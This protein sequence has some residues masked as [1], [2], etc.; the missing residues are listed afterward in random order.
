MIRNGQ[1]IQPKPKI[2]RVSREIPI[3]YFQ[4]QFEPGST[5]GV[6]DRVQDA[7][8]KIEKHRRKNIVQYESVQVSFSHSNRGIKSL[9]DTCLS[10]CSEHMTTNEMQQ[11]EHLKY[12]PAPL[13]HSLW[14]I[15]HRRFPNSYK[16]WI[17]SASLWPESVP[18]TREIYAFVDSYLMQDIKRFKDRINCCIFVKNVADFDPDLVWGSMNDL[19][20]LDLHRIPLHQTILGRIS[21]ST[22]LR[23]E[24]FKSLRYLAIDW[25]SILDEGSQTEMGKW[26]SILPNLD[27]VEVFANEIIT[28]IESEV[29][30][31]STEI[32]EDN[33]Q[34][35]Q[36]K[37][38]L[39]IAEWD[40]DFK[41]N[42]RY[43]M[44][45]RLKN[46]GIYL[47]S[48]PTLVISTPMATNDTFA[49]P[50]RSQKICFRRK[51]RKVNI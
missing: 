20:A 3:R 35:T 6:V 47:D 41:V 14:K 16:A 12:L 38:S 34:I 10:V 29:D 25:A 33:K 46:A 13:R 1:V 49:V 43:K 17:V 32:L 22:M 15:I 48:R 44:I 11:I 4:T 50:A 8:G 40:V 27:C 7:I 28:P 39:Q 45:V 31:G 18:Q 30:D 19:V 42:E 36:I 5:V 9:V 51:S 2:R 23:D 26:I 21:R 37:T 24:C